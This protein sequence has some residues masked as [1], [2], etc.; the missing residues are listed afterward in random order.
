MSHATASPWVH[1][2]FSST[3]D[4]R[5]LCDDEHVVAPRSG[6]SLHAWH[7]HGDGACPGPAW[8]RLPAQRAVLSLLETVAPG[9]QRWGRPSPARAIASSK[10]PGRTASAPCLRATPPLDTWLRQVARA[11]SRTHPGPCDVTRT[12]E[13]CHTEQRPSHTR[14][15]K[16]TSSKNHRTPKP[17]QRPARTNARAQS[18]RLTEERYKSSSARARTASAPRTS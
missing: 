11:P 14:D 7:S 1:R 5:P 6:W 8:V 12:H 16:P 10:H 4:E 9:G 17:K 3:I 18:K 15:A 13:G 2:H